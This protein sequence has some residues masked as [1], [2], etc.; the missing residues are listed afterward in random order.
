V[1]SIT[2]E[3]GIVKTVRAKNFLAPKTF[4]NEMAKRWILSRIE[5]NLHIIDLAQQ[6]NLCSNLI[7]GIENGRTTKVN[8][9]S[10][11]IVAK[12]LD[13]PIWYI[14]CYDLLPEESFCQQI[15]KA[16]LYHGMTKIEAGDY[17]G[18]NNKTYRL[19]EKGTHKPDKENQRK[20]QKYI[21]ILYK[22]NVRD[23]TS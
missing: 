2:Q 8:I 13:K 15:K 10:V 21:E 5:K 12:I 7:S 23:P 1:C 9:G 11:K 3:I 20:L 4:P 18:V 16:R 14:G 17:L 6:V 19:W 22:Q